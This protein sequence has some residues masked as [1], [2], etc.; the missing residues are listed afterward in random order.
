MSQKGESINHVTLKLASFEGPLDLLLHL[1]K[2]A[3]MDIYDI[4]ISSI[5]NQ[6]LSIIN[7]TDQMPLDTIGQYLVMA[8]T[9]MEIKSRMLLPVIDYEVEEDE[10]D[11]RTDL[12]EQLIEYQNFK[13]AS[14]KLGAMASN[15]SDY[16]SKEQSRTP[17]EVVD[18]QPLV[19]PGL[20]LDV[21]QNAFKRVLLRQVD[22][23]PVQ[24][25]I[26]MQPFSLADKI[27]EIEQILESSNGRLTF[28]D[29]FE[30]PM[31]VSEIVITFLAILELSKMKQIKLKQ[32]NSYETIQIVKIEA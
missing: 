12:V 26:N 1:I 22:R 3:E 7:R 14:N 28:D 32:T 10:I 21:L 31:V 30:Q 6:Y 24:K 15:R 9:L 11:P 8:S 17:K 25:K 27:I 2:D 23:Q 16:F 18:E 5:T 13:N 29:L 4:Q 20:S 19:I